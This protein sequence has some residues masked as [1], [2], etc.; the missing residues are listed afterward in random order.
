MSLGL[1]ACETTTSSS[2]PESASPLAGWQPLAGTGVE[3]ERLHAPQTTDVASGRA[4]PVADSPQAARNAHK[5]A[6]RAPYF[7]FAT[8]PPL[9]HRWHQDTAGVS[10]PDASNCS[11]VP[12]CP[13]PDTWRPGRID[14]IARDVEP[15]N[16]PGPLHGSPHDG[17]MSMWTHK[18]DIRPHGNHGYARRAVGVGSSSCLHSSMRLHSRRTLVHAS[19]STLPARQTR[20]PDAA[21]VL[22]AMSAAPDTAAQQLH[23]PRPVVP[24]VAFSMSRCESTVGARMQTVAERECALCCP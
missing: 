3:A 20:S 15:R 7:K 5:P 16:P 2:Q 13:Q 1:T 24:A 21:S 6:G 19:S 11:R 17:M 14:A 12:V 23:L 10:L 22:R 9:L 18:P 8:P 4:P